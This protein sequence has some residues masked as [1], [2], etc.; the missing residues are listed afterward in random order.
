MP[1]MRR[2]IH[3]LEPSNLLEPLD[4]T[5]QHVG[6]VKGSVYPDDGTSR[7]VFTP[8]IPRKP[9]AEPIR[10]G[11]RRHLKPVLIRS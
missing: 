6:S 11:G 10:D 5:E 1:S 3:L 2:P 8:T 7:T 4:L 9:A